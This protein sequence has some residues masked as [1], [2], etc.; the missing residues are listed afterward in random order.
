MKGGQARNAVVPVPDADPR[1][2]GRRD[3]SDES[4]GA[5]AVPPPTHDDGSGSHRPERRTHLPAHLE[6]RLRHPRAT[7]RGHARDAR[8]FGVEDGRAHTEDARPGEEHLVARRSRHDA[9]PDE[10]EERAAGERERHRSPIGDEPHRGL[11]EGRRDLIRKRH[12]ADL[13]ES[14]VEL[15]FDGWIEC[16]EERL[17]HVVYQM[18]EANRRDHSIDGPVQFFH[19]R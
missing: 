8:G 14:K 11:Q 18:T 5:H 3:Q 4:E 10:R 1:Q 16:H 17:Q 2:D 12:R 15:A 6:Q 7:A 9:Q 13:C 19:D